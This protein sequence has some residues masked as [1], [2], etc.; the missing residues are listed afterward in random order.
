M[1]A[2]E[3]LFSDVFVDSLVAH[4]D[5]SASIV[6]HFEK[7]GN[8]VSQVG[9]CYNTWGFPDITDNV[10]TGI[11]TKSQ[12]VVLN[13][14]KKGASYHLRA[15]VK[16]DGNQITYSD[17]ILL[18][19]K[20]RLDSISTEQ[21]GSSGYCLYFM[22]NQ[23]GI[24]R[25]PKNDAF[26]LTGSF[27]IE[28]WVYLNNLV[29]N[30]FPILS[31]SDSVR[32]GNVL[33]A[34]KINKD[35]KIE[36][37]LAAN[38]DQSAD[39][40]PTD[41]WTHIAVSVDRQA[42]NKVS[43]YINGK[44]SSQSN[45]SFPTYNNT[46][47]LIFGS[48]GDPL[49][50]TVSDNNYFFSGKMDEI[51]IWKVALNE[52]TIRNWN[53]FTVSDQHPFYNSLL[54]AYDLNQSSGNVINDYLN[55]HNGMIEGYAVKGN[56]Y[57]FAGSHSKPAWSKS[58]NDSLYDGANY[59]PIVLFSC[60]NNTFSYELGTGKKSYTGE[61][62]V[63]VFTL[64]QLPQETDTVI[65]EF[66]DCE[67]VPLTTPYVQNY[68]GNPINWNVK[69][70]ELGLKIGSMIHISL[71]TKKIVFNKYTFDYYYD[72]GVIVNPS[73]SIV[74]NFF[75][76]Y[77]TSNFVA[78]KNV[79]KQTLP[80]NNIQ[81]KLF[82]LPPRTGGVQVRII[83]STGNVLVKYN[84]QKNPDYSDGSLWQPVLSIRT[85]TLPLK[86]RFIQVFVV[87]QGATGSVGTVLKRDIR[88]VPDSMIVNCH[89]VDF[90]TK[91][92]KTSYANQVGKSLSLKSPVGAGG[93]RLPA[94]LK[95]NNNTYNQGSFWLGSVEHCPYIDQ[96]NFTIEAWIKPDLDSIKNSTCA[97]M[98]VDQSWNLQLGPVDSASGIAQMS[99]RFYYVDD[100]GK[101]GEYEFVAF[102]DRQLFTKNC[103]H[104]IAVS[105]DSIDYTKYRFYVDGKFAGNPLLPLTQKIHRV[106]INNPFYIGYIPSKYDAG[107]IDNYFG[108]IDEVR[109][110][111]RQLSDAE[112]ANNYNRTIFPEIHLVAYW[113]FDNSNLLN[114]VLDK[115]YYANFG[116]FDDNNY[117]TLTKQSVN[118][119]DEE[120]E[121]LSL[122][123]LPS[124]EELDSVNVSIIDNK[125]YVYDSQKLIAI[126]DTINY[127]YNINLPQGSYSAVISEYYGGSC[128]VKR[129][130]TLQPINALAPRPNLT[131]QYESMRYIY[132]DNYNIF[133]NLMLSGFPSGTQKVDLDLIDST[134][135]I[136]LDGPEFTRSSVPYGN[137]LSCG[138]STKAA[139]ADYDTLDAGAMSFS[140]WFKTSSTQGGFI[141]GY[142]DV[143]DSLVFGIYAD[144][145]GRVHSV[146]NLLT[147]DI[148]VTCQNAKTAEF[149]RGVYFVNENLGFAV[150]MLS[151]EV[152]G[153]F[154]KTTDGG[155]NW[156][157]SKWGMS[158]HYCVFFPDETHGW[159]AGQ[160]GYYYWTT[161]GGN[162]FNSDPGVAYYH[163]TGR[164]I[165]SFHFT[166]MN[167]GAFCNDGYVWSTT[168]AL[169]DKWVAPLA[170]GMTAYNI[171]GVSCIG[172]KS[173]AVGEHGYVY[174]S[175][176]YLD[177]NRSWK[178]WTKK[179]ICN[180]YLTDVFFVDD[181]NGWIVGYEGVIYHT[182]NGGTD[183]TK[184]N[185]S[186]TNNLTSVSFL[187]M[188]NGVVSGSNGT[189]LY[190]TNGGDGWNAI[191]TGT[192]H[193]L[194]KV[195]L[196]GNKLWVVGNYG[197][198]IRIDNLPFSEKKQYASSQSS[199][200]DGQWHFFT[201]NY[202]VYAND[203]PQVLCKKN[204]QSDFSL[205][206]DGT[207]VN[208]T[209]YFL[210]PVNFRSSIIGKYIFAYNDM[211]G[212]RGKMLNGYFDGD[213]TE[214]GIHKGV[215]TYNSLGHLMYNDKDWTNTYHRWSFD[216]GQGSVSHD[217]YG[218]PL[219]ITGGFHW[220]KS[221]SLQ[222]A[223]WNV[224][225]NVLMPGEYTLRAKVYYPNGDLN[226][227]IAYQLTKFYNVRNRN[228]FLY[229]ITEGLGLYESG[230][231][232]DCSIMAEMWK[233]TISPVFKLY[234][235]DG[236]LIDYSNSSSYRFD[237][238]EVTPGSFFTI[239]IVSNASKRQIDS[240]CYP[241]FIKPLGKPIVTG[242]FK[243]PFTESFLPGL[244]S[245]LNKIC[246][247]TPATDI[248]IRVFSLNM[249]NVII[250][251]TLIKGADKETD[252]SFV[253]TMDMADL[254][255]PQSR[256]YFDVYLGKSTLPVYT[257][258]PYVSQISQVKPQWM[259]LAL[260]S[261]YKDVVTKNC[262]DYQFTLNLPYSLKELGADNIHEFD[263]P[264]GIPFIGGTKN[265]VSNEGID[266]KL[267]YNDSTGILGVEDAQV[268]SKA[269]SF[270]PDFYKGIAEALEL[271]GKKLPI[272]PFSYSSS[273]DKKLQIL[274][275]GNGIAY[276]QTSKSFLKIDLNITQGIKKMMGFTE[277]AVESLD[278][279]NPWSLIIHPEISIDF[280]VSVGFSNRIH[281][282]YFA[283]TGNWE[284]TGNTDVSGKEVSEDAASY[285]FAAVVPEVDL[286]L[287][288][289]ML[290]GLADLKFIFGG[291]VPVAFGS[292]YTSYPVNDVKTK[293]TIRG[294]ILFKIK[295][296]EVWGLFSQTIYHKYW[297]VKI[298]GDNISGSI[299]PEDKKIMRKSSGNNVAGL[300]NT[301]FKTLPHIDRE[302]LPA[303][304]HSFARSK[305]NP[306][307]TWLEFSPED[308]GVRELKVAMLDKKNNS[309]TLPNNIISN[310]KLI[311]NP[312]A[313]AIDS[314]TIIVTWEQASKLP[315]FGNLNLSSYLEMINSSDIM[316]AIYNIQADSLIKIG[317]IE[318]P[319]GK[320]IAY[321]KPS[322]V[323]TSDHSVVLCWLGNKIL[324]GSSAAFSDLGKNQN[325]ST[326][327]DVY[328]S[329]LIRNDN[330]WIGKTPNLLS[331][332]DGVDHDIQLHAYNNKAILIWKNIDPKQENSTA[333]YYSIFSEGQWSD[334]KPV[335]TKVGDVEIGDF[336]FD[337]ND[338]GLGGLV[339]TERT[340]NRRGDH[341]YL[342]EFDMQSD[343][344]EP[345]I[346]LPFDYNKQE[347]D[348]VLKPQISINE[349]GRAAIT[350]LLHSYNPIDGSTKEN[351]VDLILGSMINPHDVWTHYAANEFVCDT[352]K[353]TSHYDIS[354]TNNKLYVLSQENLWTGGV[355]HIINPS[356][357]LKFGKKE[358]NV[359]LRSVNVL[360]N[361]A[362]TK[363]TTVT[364][365]NDN[366]SKPYT[367]YIDDR[368]PYLADCTPNPASSEAVI[369]YF[370][371]RCTEDV[372][373]ELYDIVGNQVF[374]M[375]NTHMVEGYYE[376]II[377]L[378][379]LASGTYIVM[380][381][382]N[383]QVLTKRLVVLK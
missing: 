204:L 245:R 113:N 332:I 276:T 162:K 72:F 87:Y 246:V 301:I 216:D 277:E 27:T 56:T 178:N 272:E 316:Y 286:T 238:G 202:N 18:K 15:F 296:E 273:L 50:K 138:G 348:N 166:D 140:G 157:L 254:K 68:S 351:Q 211:T 195:S 58:N 323:A 341:L 326:N 24:F 35:Y 97:I 173:W 289:K 270:D 203:V 315:S 378:S 19:P 118:I 121:K 86:S 244:H 259:E 295:T 106:N 117:A 153:T 150:G 230:S 32:D 367:G 51:R 310:K 314:A 8:N 237:L 198:I 374:K 104:Y 21:T 163:H 337:V 292:V 241:L 165:G 379:N 134:G 228:I 99:M 220:N 141:A 261:S 111:N 269:V 278:D 107:Q 282:E 256:T 52:S 14:L 318:K 284:D 321:G 187:D 177:N 93:K 217:N 16:H 38:A 311:R 349:D 156:Q 172:S 41:S 155:N 66:T 20:N 264:E 192:P 82:D 54:L 94:Y 123:I 30:E 161:D 184:Q 249:N 320:P 125:N 119:L 11:V 357:G 327:T 236:S 42:N 169:A 306:L 62:S 225:P 126:N 197:T 212:Y 313:A 2:V 3:P 338:F 325:L 71:K 174:S 31:L 359:V 227:G 63:T 224:N 132:S 331:A 34:L 160:E 48:I 67:G 299:F 210:S 352:T 253:F 319:A 207:K 148:Q 147:N 75:G 356:N 37:Q 80:E 297:S 215:T 77:R 9:L 214:I 200:N 308:M 258:G 372:Q 377:D 6:I 362:I 290:T 268:Q 366:D 129:T 144:E 143:N 274:Q 231:E 262:V 346:M 375:G 109:L 365:V 61:D 158:D 219:T 133:N 233:D 124:A 149:L 240:V 347:C 218:K 114:Y 280:L 328:Y 53:H 180:Q 131:A 335:F 55:D 46:T 383:S 101:S 120:G 36:M 103:W 229:Q 242:D 29:N 381:R 371:P 39:A 213:I 304:N 151:G 28:A 70:S 376:T 100:T 248:N 191:A 309:V 255:P 350:V 252:T 102:L 176:N 110:W 293:W 339:F 370:I 91:K 5:T 333:I 208:E 137:S 380:L 368:F 226:N 89:Q 260:D 369:N 343:S 167:T 312:V 23:K 342:V 330:Q 159:V 7:L 307:I 164:D 186:T 250:R 69:L 181:S 287:D 57:I 340:P 64:S 223:G 263:I 88:M 122:T 257:L 234:R 116:F 291:N 44:L 358:M 344:W 59:R 279:V 188:N 49:L 127:N 345:K 45:L 130:Q 329:E 135:Q 10:V 146:Y 73:D 355:N 145:S 4:D 247:N 96:E 334:H 128:I 285:S 83:D 275:P 305:G 251:D 81:L 317:K 298:A 98:G 182:T 90:G 12:I 183:W 265:V 206:I 170:G 193:N 22:L 17:N 43:F 40:I 363:D 232:S 300:T 33:Y 65:F 185:S 76:P 353:N 267:K 194:N 281:R 336:D 105:H 361:N 142:K 360:S 266:L 283:E 47:D 373:I 235:G 115:G 154:L 85:D 303:S 25:V 205:Y 324:P 1:L 139:S 112:I 79:I 190:T 179:T 201:L 189:L 84:A 354:F 171:A 74:S 322:V 294:G 168:N 209:D 364:G 136:A 199:Y 243:G 60:S 221:D 108:E 196:I 175:N 288:M 152:G 222:F 271:G 239:G 78:T 92:F 95:A 13:A 26:K 302:P 382:A